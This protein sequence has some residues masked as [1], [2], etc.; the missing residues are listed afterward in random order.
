MG[1][2][3]GCTYFQMFY[4]RVNQTV[5]RR[6]VYVVVIYDVN[7]YHFLLGLALFFPND[8][9]M[10]R[11]HW[12]FGNLVWKG[13]VLMNFVFGHD[14]FLFLNFVVFLNTK[15]FSISIYFLAWELEVYFYH[16]HRDHVL[17]SS[18]HVHWTLY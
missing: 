18:F 12:F 15:R 3:Y 13:V 5:R 10:H 4:P 2:L 6:W 9:T 14:S 1:K 11:N 8:R 16:K 17:L 7:F